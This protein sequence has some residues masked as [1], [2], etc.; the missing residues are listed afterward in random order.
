MQRDR[1]NSKARSEELIRAQAQKQA[2]AQAT[3][4]AMLTQKYT[5]IHASIAE[6]EEK[7]ERLN[8]L[9]IENGIMNQNPMPEERS[10]TSTHFFARR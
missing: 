6:I 10:G 4:D 9:L 8:N 1:E 2:Q 3:M 5:A 7:I